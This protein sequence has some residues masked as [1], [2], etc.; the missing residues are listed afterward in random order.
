MI[1]KK[2]IKFSIRF[3]Y[4]LFVTF[5]VLILSGIHS[6]LTIQNQT[7]ALKNEIIERAKVIVRKL[8]NDSRDAIL[9]KDDLTLFAGIK[10]TMAE[11]DILY[12]M[13]LDGNKIP[14]CHNDTKYLAENK[15]PLTDRITVEAFKSD[16]IL[17]Q[18]IFY[19]SQ[20]SFDVSSP[21]IWNM[22]KIGLIRIGFSKKPIKEAIKSTTYKT[23]I[24]A[25]IS[26]I[27]G[28]LFTILLTT[29]IIEPIKV[30]MKGVERISSGNFDKIIKTKHHDEFM[31]LANTFN[32]MQKS[33]KQMMT[34]IAKQEAV[35][36][37]LEIA[38]EIQKML[39]PKESP[40]IDG[41]DITGYSQQAT[42]VGGDYFDFSHID[43]SN[44]GTILADVS[45]HG[46]SAALIMVMVRM[47]FKTI[48]K[49]VKTPAE[50]LI[51]INKL[52]K[53]D[54]LE[55]K[56]VTM[57]YYNYNIKTG[58]L[59]LSSAGHQP[60][61]W[62]KFNEKKIHE[63]TTTGFPIGVVDNFEYKNRDIT[64][65]KGDI[66]IAYTD[67]FV[68]LKNENRDEFG[69][70]RLKDIVLKHHESSSELITNHIID[71]CSK[72]T[73]LP[74]QDDKTIVILKVVE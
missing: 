33:I 68:E 20:S 37:E 44:L 71:A 41:L 60:L 45:G 11:K 28:V 3:K 62:F 9:T 72:F 14:I 21:I 26:I 29:Y 38:S 54:L 15:S 31:V 53:D 23:I 66:I 27:I 56:F 55:E 43:K 18:D 40:K 63:V 32:E 36:R 57:I 58:K 12:A 5:L 35:K 13:I 49:N 47:I 22:K 67:G 69:F 52:L 73:D 10:N 59:T 7:K 1:K 51:L 74:M 16:T 65:S 2:V 8:A 39:I 42:E 6:F 48:S 4:I 46:I 17:V 25:F 70:E 64:L 50:L 24:V 30:L 34:E 61:L 19:K